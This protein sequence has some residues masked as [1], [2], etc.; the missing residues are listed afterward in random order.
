MQQAL[1]FRIRVSAR[2]IMPGIQIHERCAPSMGASA[3]SAVTSRRTNV[4]QELME[5]ETVASCMHFI[6]LT[7]FICAT[8]LLS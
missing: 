4:Y 5:G 6:R 8:L 2:Y 1:T 7:V 3:S